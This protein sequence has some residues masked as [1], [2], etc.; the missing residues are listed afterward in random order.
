MTLR[1]V[2][3]DD[4]CMVRQ[5]CR[6]ILEREGFDVV[7]EASD[8]DEAVQLV[9]LH[10]PDVAVL[11]LAMPQVNGLDAAHAI[12]EA[13][14]DA[15]IVILSMH[16][17]QY[18]VVA[19][20]RRGV[21]GYVAKNQTVHDLTHAIREVACGSVFLS[22][23]LRGRMVDRY[24]SGGHVPPD[25]LDAREQTLLQLVAEGRTTKEIA[26][27]LDVA[28]KTAE[29]Q[30][31]RLM[32]KLDVRDIAGLVRYAV[33]RGLIKPAMAFWTAIQNGELF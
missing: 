29:S 11:D 23:V 7:G 18:Q 12:L 19:A 6:A 27:R 30:R 14:P 8:G 4:H 25:P 22:S 3:A 32:S 13:I 10:R 1:L 5:G 16:T 24:L 33:R 2:I 21:R 9:L 28:V 31:A 26:E 17:E 15:A 20:L